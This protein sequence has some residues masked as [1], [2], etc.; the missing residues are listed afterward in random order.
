MNRY[1]EAL[2]HYLDASQQAG[3]FRKANNFNGMNALP[4]N[5]GAEG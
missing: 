3:D 1:P 4:P 2:A 5:A